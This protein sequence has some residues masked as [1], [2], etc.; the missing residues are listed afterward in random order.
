M[1]DNNP[2][3]AKLGLDTTNFKANVVK[4][5]REMR[6]VTSE[7][8][9][10]SAA[11]GDWANDADGMGM[12]VSS[13]TKKIDLQSLKIENLND[14]YAETVAKSG[15]TSAAAKNLEIRLNR[16]R[17]T[18]AKMNNELGDAKEQHADLSREQKKARANSVAV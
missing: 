11:L 2:L 1:T 9:A 18:L 7:F 10:S 12:R 17:E 14:Q 13:L 15:E 8:R 4:I 16:E 5:N 3:S 6:L